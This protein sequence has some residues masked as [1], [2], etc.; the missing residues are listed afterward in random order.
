MTMA[1][2]PA[3]PS[4]S[5]NTKGTSMT[6]LFSYSFMKNALIAILIISPA[7]GILGTMVVQ[8]QMAYFSD[9][10]GHSAL[11]GIAIGTVLGVT[12]AGISMVCFGVVFALILNH[13]KLKSQTSVD[14]LIS[15]CASTS[16]ALG[17]AILSKDGNFSKYSSL[18]VGDVLSIGSDQLPILALCA[19]A[20]LIYYCLS[21]NALAATSIHPT[22]AKSNLVHTVFTD[23]LFVVITAMLVML[24]IRW[25]GV[26]LIN[27]MLILPAASARN[28]A[29]NM[30][31][32]HI[33]T[34]AIALF[35]GVMGL[36]VSYYTGVATGPVIVIYTGLI[37]FITYLKSKE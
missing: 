23:D 31:Q 25:I 17:L 20:T 9:A 6:E 7:L 21:L 4:L 13:I 29:Y 19:A 22:L 15:V 37:Y 33:Y 34:L 27:A 35:S 10:L 36:I 5:E 28:I 3:V 32:Y 18:L 30:R 26:L 1:A 2:L 16:L 24:S 14:T 12:N 11:T 8:R